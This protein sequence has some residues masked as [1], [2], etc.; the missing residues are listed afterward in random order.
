MDLYRANW[1]DDGQQRW[2]TV[3]ASNSLYL[4]VLVLMVSISSI[5]FS[6]LGPANMNT[7]KWLVVTLGME[8]IVIGVP[9]LLYLMGS[10]MDI[11]RVARINRVRGVELLLVLGMAVFGYAIV[12]FINMVWY[13]I[14]SRIGNPVEP[15]LPPIRTSRQYIMAIIAMA[16]TPALVEEF[17]FRG[18]ILRGYERFGIWTAMVVSGVLFGVLHL[19]LVNLPA[20]IFLG[21][22]ISYVVIRTNSLFAGMFYHFVQNFLSIS[23]LF[24]QEVAQRYLRDGMAVPENV[25]QMPPELLAAALTVWGI[26]AFF[27]LGLFIACLASFNRVT[28]GKESIRTL[29]VDETKALSLKD[30]LPAIAAIIIVIVYLGIEVFTMIKSV[31]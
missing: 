6:I 14:L 13:S 21:V 20:I 8:I 22:M 3:L 26:I 18:V 9:P 1:A 5:V 17:L 24:L 12:G 16:L 29:M 28:Y 31:Q 30:M 23:F 10:R 4:I 27:C 25:E 19:N 2:P 11:K 15:V 7:E